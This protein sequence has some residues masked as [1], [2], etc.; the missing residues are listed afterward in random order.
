MAINIKNFLN[1]KNKLSK[2]RDF[3]DLGHI[4][5][6]SISAIT[7]DLYGDGRDDIT[8]FY[9]SEGAKYAS[10]YTKSKIVS[11]NIKFNLQLKNKLVKALFINTKNANTFTGKQGF[12]SIK[13]LSKYL[14]KELTLRASRA[15]VGT[16]DVVKPNQ[17]LFAS[18]G[19]IGET[20]PVEKIKKKIP[21]LV[22]SLKTVQNKYV[23]IKAASAIK[24]TDTIPKLAFE[25]CKIGEK[26]VKIYGIAKGSGMIAPNM[27]TM[28]A[29]IFTDADLS[30][31]ILKSLL[32]RNIDSTFNAITVDGDT[33]TNDMLT[34]F[35]TGKV[36]NPNIENILDP[37]LI[38]FE[39][40]LHNVMLNLSLQIIKDGEGAKKLLKINIS[41]AQNYQSARKIA[42]SIANSPLIKTAIAGED[43]N[44]GRVIMAI[45]KSGENVNVKKLNIKFGELS[46]IKNGELNS[47]YDEK[48][49]QEYMEWDSIEINVEMN[50]GEGN[51]IAYTCDFTKDYIDI[52]TDY[53]T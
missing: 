35:S 50:M 45:G 24:T 1:V 5:G 27:A 15:E 46:I 30:A 18:T 48:I 52:N 36:N 19:V 38:N 17:I 43:P 40:K 49:V 23:W 25:E 16:N 33:S 53:R 47:E 34:F 39:K 31:N 13:E 44:W 6:I 42:F 51:Y 37:R 2:M 4:D 3:Q 9:F 20:Y 8:L 28:L 11:E 22:A 32:K 12:E 26:N 10:V 41:K 7:A 14:S 29:F 21:D